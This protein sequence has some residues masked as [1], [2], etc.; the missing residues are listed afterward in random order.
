MASNL[1]NSELSEVQ[2]KNNFIFKINLAWIYILLLILVLIY[3]YLGSQASYFSILVSFAK[4]WPIA[5]ILVGISIFRVNNFSSFAVGLLLVFFLMAITISSIFVPKTLVKD[6][7]YTQSVPVSGASEVDA[8]INLILT[9]ANFSNSN[10]NVFKGN[11]LSNYDD[12]EISNYKDPSG[13]ER[14]TLNH[15]GLPDGLGSYSKNT[16]II[17][18]S[19]IPFSFDIKLILSKLES[20]FKS[21]TMTSSVLDLI[22]SNA[23]IVISDL[24]KSSSINIKSTLSQVNLVI[25]DSI[26]VTFSASSSL[27]QQEVV[28]FSPSTVDNRIYKSNRPENLETEQK[29][30]RPELVI[31]LNSTLSKVKIIQ[32]DI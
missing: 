2:N 9:K 12:L 19:S 32:Q 17:F 3:F 22:G 28:G 31:T 24:D 30:E 10:I 1:Y 23:E 26:N 15:D 11:S 16:D 6:V 21:F 5:M 14:I 8:R 13:S 25:D 29:D 7:F 27:T 18:P 4:I 20:N